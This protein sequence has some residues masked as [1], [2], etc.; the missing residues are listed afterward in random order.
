[1]LDERPDGSRHKV[2]YRMEPKKA[3]AMAMVIERE[4]VPLLWQIFLRETQL[5]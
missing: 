2:N 4:M 5:E 3:E 1:M